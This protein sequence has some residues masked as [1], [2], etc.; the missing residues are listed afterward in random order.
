MYVFGHF[1]THRNSGG[2]NHGVQKL[3][4]YVKTCCKMLMVDFYKTFR[5][6]LVPI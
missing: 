3:V 2:R 5:P 6:K 1:N 4:A